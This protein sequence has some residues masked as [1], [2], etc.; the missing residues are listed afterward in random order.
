MRQV[1][2]CNGRAWLEDVPEPGWVIVKEFPLG[3]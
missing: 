2:L 3:A 1:V